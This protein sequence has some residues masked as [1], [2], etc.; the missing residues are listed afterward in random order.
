MLKQILCFSLVIILSHLTNFEASAS[1]GNNFE[2]NATR[3]SKIKNRVVKL[4]LDA[5][6]KINLQDDTRFEGSLQ[7]IEAEHFVIK[8]KSDGNET[9]ISYQDVKQIKKHNL[10]TA[11][12]IGI[13]AVA[14]GVIIAVIALANGREKT[15][16]KPCPLIYP[17]RCP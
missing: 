7:K 4:G 17:E 1:V 10:S 6:V 9:A 11:A 16:G 12:K 8:N 5:R 15:K 13:A 2:K 3:G 14:A